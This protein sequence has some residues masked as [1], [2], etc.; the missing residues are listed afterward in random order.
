VWKRDES[1]IAVV[2]G[3]GAGYTGLVAGLITNNNDGVVLMALRKAKGDE[4]VYLALLLR[5]TLLMIKVS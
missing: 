5:D 2:I 3:V 4:R 1:L